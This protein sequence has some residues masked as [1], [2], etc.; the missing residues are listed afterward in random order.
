MNTFPNNPDRTIPDENPPTGKK[1]SN[2][3]SVTKKKKRKKK[4]NKAEQRKEV[5]KVE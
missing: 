2:P 4:S 3:F 5:K 1:K